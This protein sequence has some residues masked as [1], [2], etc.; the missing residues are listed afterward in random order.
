[1]DHHKTSFIQR[2][3]RHF[4][5]IGLRATVLIA[6]GP[7]FMLALNPRFVSA[8]ETYTFTGL[9]FNNALCGATFKCVSGR[10]TGSITFNVPAGYTGYVADSEIQ[11]FVFTVQG[12]GVA[13]QYPESDTCF[14]DGIQQFFLLNGVVQS[15]SFYMKKANAGAVCGH[16]NDIASMITISNNGDSVLVS[17]NPPE[18]GKS[19]TEGS[20]T[21]GSGSSS[22]PRITFASPTGTVDVT[23]TTQT[24]VVGEPIFLSA[25]P[26]S[27]GIRQ[28]W[29]IEPPL[30]TANSVGRYNLVPGGSP[31]CAE[32]INPNPASCAEVTPVAPTDLTQP[33]INFYWIQPGRYTLTHADS[34]GATE[35]TTF[36]VV[37]PEASTAMLEEEGAT[38]VID[39]TTGI[40][41]DY[42]LG[43]TL[44]CGNGDGF[45][46]DHDCFVVSPHA[47]L[48]NG[49]TGNFQWVQI[50]LKDALSVSTGGNFEPCQTKVG[51]DAQYP[52]PVLKKNTDI[53]FD[54]P[55]TPLN[56]KYEGVFRSFQAQMYLEWKP[57]ITGSIPVPLGSFQWSW[58]GTATKNSQGVWSLGTPTSPVFH[59]FILSNTYPTWSS[60]APSPNSPQCP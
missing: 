4:T 6:L 59:S 48:P 53:A 58:L 16:T 55:G 49:Y 10:V 38:M 50:I 52:Y 32:V 25:S 1:M 28:Q 56:K 60:V 21:S 14:E 31:P 18:Y 43:Y 44:S 26:Q 33:S 36:D 40:Y 3:I 29:S 12:T 15:W 8:S 42:S 9:P 37:G 51:L 5:K 17:G 34:S 24:V 46:L 35:R 11:S 19:G 41:P 20:W 23:G 47:Q 27:T 30:T 2:A 22:P 54:D 45:D 7:L 13:I 57:D 39:N